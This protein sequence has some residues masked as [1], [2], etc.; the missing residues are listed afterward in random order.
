VSTLGFIA[1]RCP[2][3]N[4][5]G[6]ILVDWVPRAGEFG[7]CLQCGAVV[8]FASATSVGAGGVLQTAIAMVAGESALARSDKATAARVLVLLDKAAGLIQPTAPERGRA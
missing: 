8:Y 3:C 2:C 6:P 1:A 4:L 5:E 7:V